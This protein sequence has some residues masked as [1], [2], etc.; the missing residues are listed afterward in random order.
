MKKSPFKS[1]WE[2]YS[3]MGIQSCSKHMSPFPV[4]HTATSHNALQFVMRD[5]NLLCK[6]KNSYLFLFLKES[7]HNDV[8]DLCSCFQDI[9]QFSVIIVFFTL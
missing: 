7:F 5:K 6:F 9:L 8:H 1:L 2:K 4:P 3:L